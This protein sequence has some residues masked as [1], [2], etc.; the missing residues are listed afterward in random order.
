MGERFMVLG[1]GGMIGRQVVHQIAAQLR[2]EWIMICSRFQKEVREAAEHFK[3]EFPHVHLFG[4]WGDLF[5][6]AEWNT[7]EH[8]RQQPRAELLK[9]AAHRAAL[10]D[11][12]FGDF[13]A[14]Y[15]RTQLV[16]LILEHKP[17]VVVDCI[18]TATGIS[19]Q[20]VYTASGAAKKQFERLKTALRTES[21]SAT[22]ELASAQP[23]QRESNDEA[24]VP[25]TKSAAELIGPTG[26]AVESLLLS[27]SVPQLIRHVLMVS[28]AL[29]E[30]GARLYLKV[31]TTGTGGMGLNIPYTNSEDKPSVQLLTKTAIACAHTGLLFLMAHKAAPSSKRSNRARWSATRTSLIRRS[32]DR[33][34]SSSCIAVASNRSNRR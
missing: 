6:R 34:R 2:P 17:D 13:D 9:S 31:G 28:R 29:T 19:Y 1:G 7:Q 33:A 3:R 23:E 20:D 22:G 25:P 26:R 11:D 16:Q 18:N 10:Y 4:F 30:V 27:Q 5:L 21:A 14:A 15:A 24:T 32:G 8:R 12:L